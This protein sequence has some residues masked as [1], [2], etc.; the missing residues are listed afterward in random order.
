MVFRQ[1]NRHQSGFSDPFDDTRW[2][3]EVLNESRQEPLLK[4]SLSNLNIYTSEPFPERSFLFLCFRES[5]DTALLLLKE[6]YRSREIHP[7][8]ISH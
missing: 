4:L 5:E 7:E 8:Q 2:F 1:N 6:I 3:W